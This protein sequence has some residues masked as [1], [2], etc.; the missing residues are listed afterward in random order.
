MAARL[1]Y[2]DASWTHTANGIYAEV[3]MA[4]MI[5]A[6]FSEHDLKKLIDL[7]LSFIPPTSHL[8]IAI[9]MAC[10]W[11]TK[12]NGF[13]A[14][15]DCLDQYFGDMNKVHSVN[16]L[17]LCLGALYYGEGDL[18]KSVCL[19]VMGA[20][21]TDSAA[22]SVGSIVGAQRGRRD[23]QSQLAL[24]LKDQAKL[25]VVSHHHSKIVDLARWS[26]SLWQNTSIKS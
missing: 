2:K 18:D 21:D 7:S 11:M 23:L 4:V 15:M 14:Y 6:S 9:N 5:A 25:K 16:N 3:F 26:L 24:A 19:A 17:C 20:I 1:A 13:E 12:E 8:S 10:E 22:A